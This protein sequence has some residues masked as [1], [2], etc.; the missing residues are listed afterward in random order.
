[1]PSAAKLVVVLP[2]ENQSRAPGLDWVGESFPETI[3]SRFT[4][5]GM[6]VVERKDRQYA[7]ERAGVPAGTRV[8]RATLFRLAEEMDADYAVLGSY[9]F[10]GRTFTARAQLMDRKRLRLMPEAVESGALTQLLEIQSALAWNLLRQLELV[11]NTPKNT[12]VN[13]AAGVRLDALEN[14]V[15]GVIA[16]NR[17][18]K[19]KFLREAVRLSPAYAEAQFQLGKTLF[20][21]NDYDPAIPA[22][23]KVQAESLLYGE[24]QFYAGLANYYI[25]RY[26]AAENAFKAVVERVPLI[27]VYNNL[28]VM[29][30]RRGKD[31]RQY[32][33]RAAQADTR[34]ADYRFNFGVALYRAGDGQGAQR[35]LKDA[36]GLRPQDA[37]AKALLEQVSAGSPFPAAKPPLERVKKNYDES[38]YRQLASEIAAMREVRFAALPAP[39]HAAEHVRSGNELYVDGN[40]AAAESDF[41]EAIL[42]DPTNER[43]HVGLAKVL[44]AENELVEARAEANAANRLK[45]T[46]DAFLV[47]A[48]IDLKQNKTESAADNLARALRVEPDNTDA[49]ALQVEID[50]RKAGSQE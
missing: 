46:A 5:A 45:V 9:T 50:R 15:R 39:E 48:R 47:L 40:I 49:A 30:A 20:E 36:V 38:S 35:Q 25:G 26:E 41:R 3:G 42:L 18:D 32:F 2:F 34:D 17:A 11:P 37:E 28:G 19:L 14:Y 43:A 21:A 10:D 24:A 44:E 13:A 33:L 4:Q 1:V 8:S 7:P 31:A 27:E 12:F 16:A 29:A 22:L 23:S 6:L